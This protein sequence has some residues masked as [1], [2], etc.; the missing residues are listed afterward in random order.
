MNTG[1]S[2]SQQDFNNKTKGKSLASI[3]WLDGLV[4]SMLGFRSDDRGSN[5]GSD[6]CFTKAKTLYINMGDATQPP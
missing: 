5:P 6:T 4:V 2:I 3:Q 1:N